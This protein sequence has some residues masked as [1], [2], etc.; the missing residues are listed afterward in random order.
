MRITLGVVLS[1]LVLLVVYAVGIEPRLLLDV[2]EHEAE[3]PGLPAEWEGQKVSLLA[4]FQ[5]GMWWDNTGMV[6]RSVDEAIEQASAAVIIAGDFVYKP[7]SAVVREAVDL[8]RPIGEAGI[9]VVAV[10]GNHDY[11]M[12]KRDS[13][14]R[15]DLVSYLREQ[16]EAIGVQ[17][18]ENNTVRLSPDGLPPLAFVGLGSEWAGKS[19]PGQALSSLP[20][21]EPRLMVMHNPVSYRELPA[22]S[23]PLAV[24]GHTHGGQIRLPFTPA[25]SWMDIAEP[26]EVVADG[27]A[28]DS[29]G[30]AGNRLYVSRGTGFSLVPARLFCRPEVTVFTL[31]RSD[32]TLPERG[33]NA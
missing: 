4:D 7:D 12:M 24:A 15:P 5:V 14:Q 9:P 11:S 13:E 25:N 31:R 6:S 23:A 21:A 32:G 30:A 22:D 18:L 10:F 3:I 29:V 16:L 17:V 28:V 27:W 33:P 1:L 26:R 19:N 8:I 20:P 2:Q